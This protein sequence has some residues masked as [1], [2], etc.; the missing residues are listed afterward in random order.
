MS[1]LLKYDDTDPLSIKEYGE[2]LLGKRILDVLDETGMGDEEKNEIISKV[3]NPNYKGGIGHLVENHH[4]G[5]E[6]NSEQEPDFKKAGVELKVTAYERGKRGGYSAG[7]RLVITMINYNEPVDE[8]FFSSHVYKKLRLTLLVQYQRDRTL[9]RI[10]Y[11]I[12]FVTMFSPPEEDMK[13][14]MDDYKKIISKVKNG[15]AHELAEGETM[16]LGACTKGVNSDKS[17]VPQEYYSDGT[18]A[19]R[20]AF[21]LKQSYVTNI[22]NKYI[23]NKVNT[24][25]SILSSE[26]DIAN[27][28]IE[29][30]VLEKINLYKDKT[31]KELV[32]KLNLDV[33]PG[34]KNF[35]SAITYRMLGVK[36]NRAE[37]FEK[38]NIEV[39]TIR[40]NENGTIKENMSFPRITFERITNQ[41]W[42]ESDLYNRLSSKRFLF[43]VFKKEGDHYILKGSQFWNITNNDLEEAGKGWSDVQKVLQDGIKLNKQYKK[44]GITF[45]RMRNNLPKKNA[46]RVIHIR[47][48]TG[49]SFYKLK[50]GEVI[51]EKPVYGDELPDGQIMTIQSFWFNNSYVLSQLNEELLN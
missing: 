42:E 40:V 2:V 38:A 9:P 11:P 14:I 7:E 46:N 15:K 3:N 21:C 30:L 32:D 28:T 12:H 34:T 44:D 1:K 19:R 23:L 24:Y 13:I 43:V 37:E 20:R 33:K 4:F 16:Y 51:G 25:E 5:I 35:W 36:S 8:D 39:K 48:H 27:R 31:D 50:N 49:E 10:E 6:T 47:P 45:W 22:L 29:E 41:E 17:N 26:S 18:K